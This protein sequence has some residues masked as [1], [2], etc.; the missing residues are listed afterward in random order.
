MFYGRVYVIERG[1]EAHLSRILHQSPA[2]GA[3]SGPPVVGEASA[4]ACGTSGVS[5]NPPSQK[6]NA[7]NVKKIITQAE[8]T[9]AVYDPH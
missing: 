8:I 2:A 9:M 5:A 6:M 3:S 4:L 1:Q 7:T